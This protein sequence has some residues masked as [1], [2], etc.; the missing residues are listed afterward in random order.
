MPMNSKY[1]AVIG[2]E[3]HAQLL[4][5]T[6]IFCGCSTKFG[7]PPN[8]NVCPVCLGHP[9]VLPVLNQKVVEYTVLMGLATNCTI[10]EKSVFARKNYFYPD[11]PKDYQISQ[12][13]EPICEHGNVTVEFKDGSTKNIGITRIHME[14]DAGKSIHDQGF[15]TKIDLNRTGTPL[16]EIVSEPDMRT[17]EEAYL[18]LAKLKQVLT[19]LG[20]CDGNMEEGSLRCDAN[21]SVRLKGETKLGT[22]AEV[23]N[24]NSFSNV[25]KAIEFEI[26][27]QIDLIEEGKKVI[28]QTL[29]WDAD[30]GEAYPMRSKE[31][32]HDY[33]Y[34]PDPD[35]MPVVVSEEWKNEIKNALPELPDAR[36]NRFV[37]SFK[38][39]VYDAEIL[40]SSRRL[41]DY[42]ENV[43]AVTDDYKSASN[44][45]M[46]DVLK[47]VNDQ[48]I[49]IDDFSVPP[50][51]L[52]KLIK[53]INNKTISGKIAKEVFPEMLAS[54]KDP[55]IIVKEKNLVQI[56]DTSAIEGIID[57]IL[58]AN[59]KQVEEY[60]SGKD[61]VFGF[62]V[63]Q[64]MKETKGK[65]NPGIVN[66]LLKSKLAERKN[67]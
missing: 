24:M 1:E 6:K 15:G 14:E 59:T 11:L 47:V 12:Y 53:L 32:A 21:I 52:G 5:D 30:L 19:Y 17:A 36:R 46:T 33:R 4:T 13:E 38:L 41:A 43:L 16:M 9:G 51:N 48:K 20:I 26:E 45:V 63:G 34:L 67:G 50:E 42:Y 66:D 3:V 60:L 65:A 35:L 44:W 40:T 18:Y 8:T 54:G 64:I 25:A 62:F 7:N 27:R 23:K 31:E 29:L 28:Q 57:N 61:K 55:E 49:T 10:N 39:P 56:T 37:D 58:N 22:K 2:L